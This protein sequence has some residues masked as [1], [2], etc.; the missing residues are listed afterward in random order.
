MNPILMS[1]SI[2][3]TLLP[4][5]VSI[6]NEFVKL[7]KEIRDPRTLEAPDNFI[8]EIRLWTFKN[9][10][11][12]IFDRDLGLKLSDPET[13]MLLKNISR[14]AELAFELDILPPVWKLVGTA[15]SKE[16]LSVL[17]EIHKTMEHLLNQ[18]LD[19]IKE[20]KSIFQKMVSIDRKLAFIMVIDMLLAGLDTVSY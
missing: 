14:T 12:I 5:I 2:N 13:A 18:G 7:I 19:D 16:M 15:S 17:D 6:N 4:K 11:A 8:M 9:I 3:K 10:L 1:Q 20:K